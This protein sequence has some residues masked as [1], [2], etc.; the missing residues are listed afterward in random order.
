MGNSEVGHLT[1]GA[2]RVVYQDLTKINKAVSDGSFKE[3]ELL[4]KVIKESR[5][6][7]SAL[8]VMGLLSD[9][10]VHSHNTHLYATI[11]AAKEL[12]LEDI[13]VHAFL[14]GR[15]TAA[16]SALGYV[17][18]LSARLKDIGAGSVATISGR[19]YAMDRD[20]RW[21]RVELAYKA[22]ASGEGLKVATP[23]EAVKEAYE[24]GE[25]DEFVKPTVLGDYSGINDSDSIFFF[26]FRADRARELTRAFVDDAFSG[27][28]IAKRLSIKN[29]ITMT[30][31]D[32]ELKLPVI[33][34]KETP[35]NILAEILS[36]EKIAQ[37]RVS[38]TEKYAHVT[39]FFN[40]GIEKPFPLEDRELIESDREVATYD[41]SPAMRAIEI[42][43]AAA[44]KIREGNPGFVLMNFA[45]GDMVGH[46]GVFD[47][48]I[49]ASEAV[50][51]AVGIVV[52]AAGEKG[53][54]TLITADHGN[55][56]EMIEASS[57]E[58]ITAHSTN[59]VPF[60]LVD[61]ASIGTSIREGAGL[62]DI[63]PTVLKIMGIEIPEE[64]DG[65]PLV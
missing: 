4:K 41:E 5:D 56:E 23:E 64:M 47:A 1:M 31:Y 42:A 28:D 3:A 24:R 61:D 50:D 14:D 60:I 43:E 65:E 18:E 13:L 9:G 12:G 16:R 20:T 22:I 29:F 58:P 21:D 45:N 49:E 35:K 37:F 30:E 7:G 11:E 17:E 40:G 34:P 53:F 2:G 38:E 32:K 8:H 6:S 63:A 54:V 39:F 36:Q 25:N 52:E 55:S 33:F 62:K 51:R 59:P 27:F 10:G 44:K 26:N 48:A 57:G 15:D 46:T 19:Y